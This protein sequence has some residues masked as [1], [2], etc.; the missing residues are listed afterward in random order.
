M[1]T[2]NAYLQQKATKLGIESDVLFDTMLKS[3]YAY[4][5]T[6][7]II[8]IIAFWSMVYLFRVSAKKYDESYD[9]GWVAGLVIAPV[10]ALAALGFAG[11][12]VHHIMSP[13]SYVISDLEY[14]MEEEED[15]D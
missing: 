1:T 8:A 6:A 14:E 15:D 12:G 4:G 3:E 11:N 10:I 13:E 7:T 9:E 2:S 5:V